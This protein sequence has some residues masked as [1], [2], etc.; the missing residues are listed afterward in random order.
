MKK[1]K[2]MKMELS[3][4]NIKMRTDQDTHPEEVDHK[5]AT[6][7]TQKWET[8]ELIRLMHQKTWSMARML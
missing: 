8:I 4:E 2:T 6:E 7:K 5:M 1:R 3:E